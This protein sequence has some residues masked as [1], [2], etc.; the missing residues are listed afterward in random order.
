MLTTRNKENKMN[1]PNLKIKYSYELDIDFDKLSKG[2]QEQ[3]KQAK[4]TFDNTGS[5][6]ELEVFNEDLIE[7][8]NDGEYEEFDMLE[9]QNN[10]DYD[11]LTKEIN[12]N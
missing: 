7:Y 4:E 2:L 5:E 1:K 12:N 6:I 8:V 9:M 11:L 3:Y 10:M